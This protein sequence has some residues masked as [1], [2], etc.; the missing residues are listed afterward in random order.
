MLWRPAEVEKSEV[1]EKLNGLGGRGGGLHPL[2]QTQAGQKRKMVRISIRVLHTC[3][4]ATHQCLSTLSPKLARTLVPK[5]SSKSKRNNSI[6]LRIAFLYFF[7]SSLWPFSSLSFYLRNERLPPPFSCPLLRL[8]SIDK[9]M[10]KNATR[11][12]EREKVRAN[13]DR[14]VNIFPPL[15][16]HTWH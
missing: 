15:P 12:R 11:G 16:P 8:L 2:D 14:S 10:G 7:L 9:W 3:G 1:L 5:T 4:L 13:D 6:L